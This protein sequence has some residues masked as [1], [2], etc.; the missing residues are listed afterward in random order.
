M[1][2]NV[3]I[4]SLTGSASDLGNVKRALGSTAGA[5]GQTASR[6]TSNSNG[7]SFLIVA[8][9]VRGS[10]KDLNTIRSKIG[11]MQNG[12]SQIASTYQNTERSVS[13]YMTIGG[14][15][16]D[17]RTSGFF[18]DWINAGV[19]VGKYAPGFGFVIPGGI[20]I[21]GQIG[22]GALGGFGPID[23]KTKVDLFHVS[24]EKE[25][26][27]VKGS[28]DILH[29][30]QKGKGGTSSEMDIGHTEGKAGIK[31]YSKGKKGEQEGL[32]I[33]GEVSGEID[34]LRKEDKISGK[35][36]E[37]S[38][39]LKIGKI[40]AKGA[41]GATLFKNGKFDPSLKAEAKAEAVG[42]EDKVKGRLG[43]KDNNV[44]AEAKGQVGYAGAEA[45]ASISKKGIE[46]KAGAEAYVA[47]GEVKGGFNLF[48]IKVDI[49]VE[50]KAL[51]AGASAEF[52]GGKSST[53]GS[54]DLGLGL[55]AGV[56][57]DVDWSGFK[58]PKIKLPSFKAPRFGG[59]SW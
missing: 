53:S 10:Q 18:K 15:I 33:E 56:K 28:A 37:A 36:G 3:N 22:L 6:I 29:M 55:G 4:K 46:A 31:I 48:G 44:H 2:I 57:W 39:E 23:G 7:G 14:Q 49:G 11:A 24:G 43:S 8:Q 40:G 50:G 5:V 12:L 52:K 30:E 35:Y 54:I 21:V 17:P 25:G 27:E 41:I 47:K 16:V 38:N 20:G 51:G 59:G 32:G 42:V 1:Q 58:P 9:K 19:K 13:F 26:M 34:I 45:K